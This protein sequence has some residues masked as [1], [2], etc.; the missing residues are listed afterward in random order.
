VGGASRLPN[1]TDTA[2]AAD[3]TRNDFDGDGLAGFTGTPA[4][5]EARNTPGT[6]NLTA[7]D[8]Q[9]PV[10]SIDPSRTALWPPN[11]R[12]IE[13][14]ITV[15]V[16]DERE[17]APTY[18]LTSV[19]SNEPDDGQGDGHTRL[20]IRDAATGTD[21]L[22]FLLRSE[23]SGG[24][25]GREYTIVYTATDGAGNTSTASTVVS[26]PHDQ[27]GAALVSTGFAPD[28]TSFSPGARLSPSFRRLCPECIVA[29]TP[30][31]SIR[32][33]RTSATPRV[34]CARPRARYRGDG[35]PLDD[36][37]LHPACRPRPAGSATGERRLHSTSRDP[38]ARS[39]RRASSSN[40]AP[41]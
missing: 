4:L 8:L 23:R 22:C 16:S 13:V 28:G 31:T 40:S 37:S 1:G 14:C 12:L 10:I 5:L 26:V 15:D 35:R 34:W 39:I 19:T 21:D 29:W 3:W 7:I 36:G 20:D 38:T 17:P 41:G 25:E 18:V 11:H 6:M 2:A 32:I 24:G 30:R 27:S 33:S 9:P